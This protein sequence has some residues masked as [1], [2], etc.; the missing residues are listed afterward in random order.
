MVA[1]CERGAV[2]AALPLAA[3]G[4]DRLQA[5]VGEFGLARQRLRLGAN[6]GGVGAVAG[7]VVAHGGEL[8]SVSRAGGKL[9]KR[10]GGFSC[11]SCGFAAVGVR[12]VLRFG[13]RG[14]ARGVAVDLA[15]GVGMTLARGVGVALRIARGIARGASA[16][17]AAFSSASAVSS[18]CRGAASERA[19]SSSASISTRRARSASRRAAPVGA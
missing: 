5:A 9:F 15:F 8:C 17:A 1:I 19:C 2:L 7:D 11:A 13:E 10:D 16:A 12:R 6:L 14:M 4:D 18:S 3:L